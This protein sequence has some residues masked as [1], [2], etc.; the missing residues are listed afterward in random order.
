LP[1]RF[2]MDI[3]LYKNF[4]IAGF[5]I[6]TFMN[7]Y[8]LLDFEVINSVYAD[9]GDPDQPLIFPE[10]ANPDYFNDPSRYA[11]PRRIQLGAKFSF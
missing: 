5:T 3:N 9:S 4:E 8:N 6:Q 2:T 10:T 7:I 1:N 11:E